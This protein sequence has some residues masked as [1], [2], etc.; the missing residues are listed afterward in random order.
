LRAIKRAGSNEQTNSRD[1]VKLA[2]RDHFPPR[3]GN[4]GNC[5]E[6]GQRVN[7]KE[8]DARSV[9]ALRNRAI[10]WK[11]TLITASYQGM[12]R[13]DPASNEMAKW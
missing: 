1:R 6:V 8:R 3:R 12:V 5:S 11:P 4:E 13:G 9:S 2:N 10:L 7:V